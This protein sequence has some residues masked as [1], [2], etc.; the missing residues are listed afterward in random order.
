MDNHLHTNFSDGVDTPRDMA[1]TAIRLGYTQIT[2]TDH[3]RRDSGWLNNY[4]LEISNLRKE[5]KDTIKI[6]IGVEAKIINLEGD[7]DFDYAYRHKIDF[8]LA[9]LHRIPIGNEK[10]IH[11]SDIDQQNIGEIYNFIKE[12]IDRVLDNP[13]VD[14]LAHPFQLGSN[15]LFLPFFSKIYCNHLRD[16]VIKRKKYIEYNISKYNDCVP[17]NYWL[18]PNLKIWLGSDSHSINDM[19]KNSFLLQKITFLS[20][21]YL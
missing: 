2:F 17:Q 11:H 7:I 14:I 13:L 10:Y 12:A 19:I 16:I 18:F 6:N 9:A 1:L 5:F 21:C 3:V 4:I 8:V 15:E 20:N